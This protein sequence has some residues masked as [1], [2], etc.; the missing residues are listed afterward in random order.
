MYEPKDTPIKSVESLMLS[1][2]QAA[3][4]PKAHIIEKHL[5]ELAVWALDL[6]RPFIA[7]VE[8]NG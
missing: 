3:N 6:Q 2:E 1:I 5:A 4:H 7:G 8:Y